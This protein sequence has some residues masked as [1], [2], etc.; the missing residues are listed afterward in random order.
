[1]HIIRPHDFSAQIADALAALRLWFIGVVAWLA[2]FAPLPRDARLWLQRALSHT[3]R[4]IRL[5][6]A[7]A[8]V[9]RMRF[10]ACAPFTP[11]RRRMP[12]GLRWSPRRGSAVRFF[13]RGIALRSFAQMR[14]VIDDFD[15]VVERAFRRLPK[16]PRGGVLVMTFARADAAPSPGMTPAAEAA[17]TS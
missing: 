1:M 17:D 5:M 3:R 8:V 6:I 12:R 13:A 2:E 15:A 11:H 16:A 7:A 4:D 9:S 10:R 14:R